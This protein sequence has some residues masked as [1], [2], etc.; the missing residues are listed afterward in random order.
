MPELVVLVLDDV[1]HV[2]DILTA[3]LSAGVTGATILDS[4]GLGR[5]LGERAL[6]D[7]LPLMPSLSSLLRAREETNRTIFSVVPDGFDFD[8]L[9]KAT[10]AIT[11]PLNAPDTGIL[12]SLPVTRAVGLHRRR[13]EG[14]H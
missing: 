6:R 10:E 9:V 11:G 2:D 14:G 8:V 13:P 1:D 12:F 5:E 7:D 4:A 3:W